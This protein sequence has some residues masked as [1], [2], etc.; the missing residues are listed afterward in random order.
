MLYRIEHI[1]PA[2]PQRSGT[3]LTGGRASSITV[4]NTATLDAPADN[5]RRLHLRAQRVSWHVT[6]D[7]TQAIQHIPFDERAG[8]T[9]TNAGNASSI[10]IEVCEFSDPARTAAAVRNAQILIA[11]MLTNSIGPGWHLGHLN[12]SHARSHQ[13]W[14]Q[15]GPGRG[16][17]CPHLILPVWGSFIEG[18]RDLMAPPAPAPSPL[19]I[20][21]VHGP[22]GE[23]SG[24]MAKAIASGRAAWLVS[25]GTNHS[26]EALSWV[27][28][29]RYITL[30][31][32]PAK[33]MFTGRETH[34]VLA[35]HSD[36]LWGNEQIA[37]A[38]N[39]NGYACPMPYLIGRKL[40]PGYKNH[41]EALANM[42]ELGIN[43]T[44]TFGEA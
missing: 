19:G 26:A 17:Y 20:Y 28:A 36:W 7:D 32:R 3:K 15:Y 21:L 18:I 41:T 30:H 42:L 22:K 4:H 43:V 1:N 11:G 16:K 27:D 35:V 37:K 44:G 31:G 33:S 40:G 13:S 39:A 23:M 5:F 9:G 34:A 25:V 29:L 12:L 10:G 14:E 24:L 8:H 38:A 6:V 2:L